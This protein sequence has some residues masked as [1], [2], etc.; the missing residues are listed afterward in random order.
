MPVVRDALREVDSQKP[1]Q[2][3]YALEDLLGS[4]YARDRQAMVT[5]AVFAGTAIFL[6]VLGV[7]GALS[8]RVRERAREIGIR[9]AMGADTRRLVGWVA[10]AGLRL[11]GL[12]VV[13]G[14]VTSWLLAGTIEG[15]LFGV[16][17]TD[18][19]AIAGSVLLVAIV[20]LVATLVPSW[21][22]TRI[23]PVV[24]LRRG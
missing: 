4:T 11:V 1:A 9:V 14:L 8:Q 17:A 21:R 24:V 20:G 6:A 22:A 12:G 23:D 10:W 5:L 3:L 19:W 7:Y 18:A 2:G 15:L 16:A 13:A